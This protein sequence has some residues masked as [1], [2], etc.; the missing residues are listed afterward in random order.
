M[1]PNKGW[2]AKK[3]K[4]SYYIYKIFRWLS[5]HFPL[6]AETRVFQ[7]TLKGL[8]QSQCLNYLSM[9]I[10]P[11][12]LRT[13]SLRFAREE[14][15]GSRSFCHEEVSSQRHSIF[16][17]MQQNDGCCFHQY[18]VAS[19]Q[20]TQHPVFTMAYVL[21]PSPLTKCRFPDNRQNPRQ[22]NNY[23]MTAFIIDLK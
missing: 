14:F 19:S 13:C 9:V 8:L 6:L 16:P 5:P 2:C 11:V 12:S 17:T 1:L 21:L 10:K 18:S 23:C 22:M 4:W 7:N 3:C 15:W 20:H